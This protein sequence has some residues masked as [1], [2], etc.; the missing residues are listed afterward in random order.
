[1]Q[2]SIAWCH[3]HAPSRGLRLDAQVIVR[4]G[5]YAGGVL[6]G[7]LG[8]S[9]ITDRPISADIRE[10]FPK[11]LELAAAAMLFA[12]VVGISLGVLSARWPGGWTDRVA[13]GASYLG[14]SYPVYWVALLPILL[15]AG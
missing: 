14:V 5:H 4:F 15:F 3:R 11:T 9:Y 6:R 12:S 8:R 13:L 7:A 1:M 2:I 10:R